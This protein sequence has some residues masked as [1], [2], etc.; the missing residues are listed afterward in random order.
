MMA[1]GTALIWLAYAMLC[2]LLLSA[3]M[4]WHRANTPVAKGTYLVLS[5]LPG[6]LLV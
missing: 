6:S 1:G 3:V 4:S 2:L 5:V